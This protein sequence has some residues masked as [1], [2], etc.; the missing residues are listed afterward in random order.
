MFRR[1][2][3]TAFV[4]Q[5]HRIVCLPRPFPCTAAGMFFKPPNTRAIIMMSALVVGSAI[6][7]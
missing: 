3:P 1:E 2:V 5:R 6:E 4:P 7:R